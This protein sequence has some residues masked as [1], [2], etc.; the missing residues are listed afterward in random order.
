MV[1]TVYLIRAFYLKDNLQKLRTHTIL[2]L[3]YTTNLSGRASTFGNTLSLACE[4]QFYIVWAIVLPFVA[5]RSVSARISI[6]IALIVLSVFIRVYASM[7]PLMDL[8]GYHDWW[9]FGLFPNVWK[10]VLGSSLRL[11]PL[12]SSLRKRRWSFVGL[13]GYA[14]TLFLTLIP[15]PKYEL[16]SPFWGVYYRPMEAWGD[17]LASVSTAILLCGVSN[18]EGNF[19]LEAQPLRFVGRVSY[20]WYLWQGPILLMRR[21]QRGY[22]SMAN[23]AVAFII[24]MI[25]TIYIEEPINRRYKRWKARKNDTKAILS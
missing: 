21:W 10:M 7:Y 22:P 17:V 13:L 12:P 18:S 24:A 16:I 6:L 11:V 14:I 23:T 1:L 20:A 5:P 19:L 25:S 8:W 15:Q 9:H 2:A 4:E 3:T